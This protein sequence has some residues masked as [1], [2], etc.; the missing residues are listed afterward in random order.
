M[1][2]RETVHEARSTGGHLVVLLVAGVDRRILP[3]VRFLSRLPDTDL[4]AVHMSVD[5]ETSQRLALDWMDV[6]LSWLPLHIHD[7]GAGTLEESVRQL[8]ERQTDPGRP[9]TVVVPE[10]ELGRWWS[11][12]LHRRNARR[13]ARQL[14]PLR[15]VTTVIVPF[16]LGP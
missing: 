7:P 10:L 9:V 8:L 4:R 16:S 3:A 12:L 6:G 5:A 15:T 13:I 1:A 2:Q 14:Q 11:P